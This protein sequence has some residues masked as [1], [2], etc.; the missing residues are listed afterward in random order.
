MIGIGSRWI[1]NPKHLP[2][3]SVPKGQLIIKTSAAGVDNSSAAGFFTAIAQRGAQASIT[4]ADTYVTVASLSGAGFL[5]N[6]VSP[7]HSAAFRPTIRL[8]IDGTVYT[9]SPSADQTALYRLVLGSLTSNPAVSTAGAIGTDILGPNT[10]PDVGYQNALVG[11]VPVNATGNV[12][13]VGPESV[14]SYGLPVLR[15][16]TSCVI[17]MKASLLSGT[18]NDKVCAASYR[19]DL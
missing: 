12:A 9:I 5:F 8:T 1:T 3:V 14:L 16:E 13:V 11:G 6:C 2:I 17:E 10:A 15:F 19:L 4:V 18:A 7:T